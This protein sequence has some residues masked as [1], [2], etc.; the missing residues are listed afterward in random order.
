MGPSRYVLQYLIFLRFNIVFSC[1]SFLYYS[2]ITYLIYSLS[3]V[4]DNSYPFTFTCQ[5]SFGAFF[6]F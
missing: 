4:R 1:L 6:W 2:L 3:F 5:A